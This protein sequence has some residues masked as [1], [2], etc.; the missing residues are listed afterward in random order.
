MAEQKNQGNDGSLNQNTIPFKMVLMQ[1]THAYLRTVYSMYVYM[2]YVYIEHV[3][4]ND[5]YI[6]MCIGL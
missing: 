1:Y 2:M 5:M 6:N 3:Y 4:Q